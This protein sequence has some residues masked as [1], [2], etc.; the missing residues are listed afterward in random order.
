MP[1]SEVIYYYTGDVRRGIVSELNR[2]NWAY[3]Y[4]YMIQGGT[5]ASWQFYFP[6]DGVWAPTARSKENIPVLATNGAAQAIEAGRPFTY[7]WVT[8]GWS[9]TNPDKVSDDKHYMGFLKY[10]YTLGSIGNVAGYFDYP[11]G[12]VSGDLGGSPPDWLRQIMLL[13]HAHGTFTHLEHYLRSGDLLPGDESHT[14][15]TDLYGQPSWPHPAYEF[16]TNEGNRSARVAARKLKG[17]DEWLIVAWAAAGDDRE[18]SVSIPG[19]G[20]VTLLARAEG[21]LYQAKLGPATKLLD[22]A[23]MDPSRRVAEIL[24]S[25]P[26]PPPRPPEFR[27]N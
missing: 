17:A 27:V 20:K 7:N 3:P 2:L 12:G 13:S 6:D 22:P 5:I 24:A 9:L 11:P 15:S 25:V 19:L 14:Y 8:A 16:V 10:L 26:R 4:R 21:S 18:I 1:A 23:G